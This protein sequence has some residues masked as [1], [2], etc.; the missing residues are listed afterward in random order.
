MM[1]TALSKKEIVEILKANG[2]ESGMIV[3]VHCTLPKLGYVIGGA[4][5]V[6]DAL[7]E[8]VGYQGTILMAMHSLENSEPTFWEN[9]LTD[10]ELVPKVRE[11]MPAYHRKESDAFQMGEVAQNFRRREGVVISSHPSHAFAAWGKYAKFLCNHQ[12]LH[13]CLSEESA[14]ARLAELKASVLLLGSGYDQCTCMHLAEY[15][16]DVRPIVMQGASVEQKGVRI[17]KQYLDIA[18]DSSEFVSIGQL[19]EKNSLVTQFKLGEGEC[20]L[21]LAETAVSVAERYFKKAH[22][23]RYYQT[24]KVE[25]A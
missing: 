4:Q 8:V 12:S 13:F 16:S 15:R 21:F 20:R 2:L 17:W 9:P 7:M 18:M 24:T 22:I 10:Y 1:T 6:V 25:S 11:S 5:T 23:T 19:M 3:E 14:T